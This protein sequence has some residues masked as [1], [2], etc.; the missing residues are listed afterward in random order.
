MNPQQAE[1]MTER[2]ARTVD[3]LRAESRTLRLSQSHDRELVDRRL[4]TLE[5]QAADHEKRL[6]TATEGV[7]QFKVWFGLTS[8]GSSLLSVIAVLRTFLGG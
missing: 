3:L 1:L 7:T 4:R 6:R 5:A 2:L 8:G